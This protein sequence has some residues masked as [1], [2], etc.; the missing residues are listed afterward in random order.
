M[1]YISAA[2]DTFRLVKYLILPFVCFSTFAFRDSEW[3]EKKTK[4]KPRNIADFIDTW[5]NIKRRSS[6]AHPKSFIF[7]EK[8]CW[9]NKRRGLFV[10]CKLEI[11]T[12]TLERLDSFKRIQLRI[13]I[14]AKT[15]ISLVFKYIYTPHY[16][17]TKSIKD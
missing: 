1:K 13:F 11:A 3:E 15:G 9:S 12:R 14:L 10:W 4:F 5:T 2:R 8:Y 6:T 17:P 7:H 16:E